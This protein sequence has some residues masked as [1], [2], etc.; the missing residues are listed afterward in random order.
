MQKFMVAYGL[1]YSHRVV[2]GVDASSPELAAGTAR[3]AFDAGTL[4]DDALE[5]P[6]L[7]DDYEE[8]DGQT[9]VFDV[10]PVNRWP[11]ADASVLLRRLHSAAHRLLTFARLVDS[12]SLHADTIATWHPDAL[13]QMTLSVR[14][15]ASQRSML[16]LLQHIG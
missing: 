15:I 14:E 9:V 8:I 6:L 7:Y 3:K 10:T 11:V 2:V 12:R 16:A 1:D 4:W 13:V 5:M